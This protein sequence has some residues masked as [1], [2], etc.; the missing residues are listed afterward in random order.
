MWTRKRHDQIQKCQI[1]LKK[2][3]Y[4]GCQSCTHSP[5]SVP[6]NFDANSESELIH[7]N[8]LRAEPL[9]SGSNRNLSMPIQNWLRAAIEE[10]W[11][12]CPSL[13]QGAINSYLQI[14]SFLGQEKT[15]EL[16]G[17]WS[18]LSCKDKELVEEPKSFIHIPEEATGND[19]SLGRM[20]SGVYQLQKHPKRSP[21]DFGRRRKVPRT[22][23]EKQI[24]TERTHKGTGSANLS[25][26]L[27]KVSSIWPG[28]F[29]IHSQRAGK[30]EQDLSM[31][32]IQE[33]QFVKSSIDVELG[34]FDAKLKK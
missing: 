12:I 11:E 33:I 14:K 19:S 15:T 16:L 34:K 28:P 29:G 9:S 10:E 21:K 18:P 31:H 32:I 1:F 25:L 24:G 5:R 27:W 20:P 30:N 6:T 22:I 26:Q 4:G 3:T 23:W 8:I 2:D 17:G 13:W 7:D